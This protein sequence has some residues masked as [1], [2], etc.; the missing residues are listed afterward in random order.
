MACGFPMSNMKYAAFD[1][2]YWLHHCNVDRHLTKYLHDN[3]DAYQ[4]FYNS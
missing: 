1:I 2:L 4:E 3:Y